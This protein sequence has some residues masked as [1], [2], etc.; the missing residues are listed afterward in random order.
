MGLPGFQFI[1]DPM[2]YETR[3]HHSDMDTLDRLHPFDLEAGGGGGGDLSVQHGR[4]GEAMM[5]RKPFPHP[6]LER[7]KTAPLKG[8]YPGAVQ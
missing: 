2:D 4:S 6:E 5:P 1:Q 7:E 8:I 3:S